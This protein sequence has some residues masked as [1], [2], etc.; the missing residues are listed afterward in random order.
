M[1]QSIT[2]TFVV[3]SLQAV[4]AFY[5]QHFDATAT[6][7][8]DWYLVLRLGPVEGCNLCF[9]TRQTLDQTE[10]TGGVT[11]NL[12]VADVDAMHER[13]VTRGNLVPVMPL[14]NH[15]WGDRSFC[16]TDPCGVRLYIYRDLPAG[17]AFQ[18]CFNTTTGR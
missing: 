4:R 5:E 16:I 9:M 7:D 14:A 10:F 12:L 13:L 15:A 1:I 2:P 11:L 17:E 18:A 8:G 3:P 6:F